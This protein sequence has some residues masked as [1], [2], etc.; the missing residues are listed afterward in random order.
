MR[1]IV[2]DIETR[3]VFQDVGS[4]DP[5]ALD[6]SLVGLYDSATEKY[7]SFLQEELGTLW[8]IFEKADMLITFN[9]DHFD[10]PILN[11]Y[12]SGDLTKIKSV[13]ILREIKRAIGRRVKLDQVAEGTLGVKKSGNGLE[14]IA[15]WKRGEIEK[16][17]K[18]CLDDVRITKD[19]Y[20]YALTHGELKFK[21]GGKA[22]VIKL[23]TSGWETRE[24]SGLTHTLPF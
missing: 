9:G 23:N 22:N 18:Y 8:P 2:F 16:I 4:A 24:E 1:K 21:E 17:R 3:N 5:A 11:K 10:I 19:V 12:Y 14:A 15:W 6:L 7:S 13:D 20:E